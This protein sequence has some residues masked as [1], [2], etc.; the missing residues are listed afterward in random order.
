MSYPLFSF[1]EL[2]IVWKQELLFVI[3]EYLLLSLDCEFH[4][5]RTMPG[6]AHHRAAAATPAPGT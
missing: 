2:M 5:L 6:V 3:I 4:E 1:Q